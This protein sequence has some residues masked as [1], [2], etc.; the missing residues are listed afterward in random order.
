VDTQLTHRRPWL[1]TAGVALVVAC[2]VP[3][4]SL[5]ARRYLFVESVQFC[6]FAMAAP[7]LAVLG[8]PLPRGPARLLRRRRARPGGQPAADGG[9]HRPSFLPV[10]AYL[11]V[12]VVIC[13]FWRLPPVLDH[14]ARYPLLVAAE[15]VTLCAAGIGLW[16]ELI[17]SPSP[18]PG[19]AQRAAAAALAMWSIWAIAYVLGFAGGSV[20]HGYDGG[21]SHLL[22]VDDQQI[23]A[24]VLW[25]A[26]AAAFLPIVFTAGLTWL[27]DGSEPPREPARGVPG[28][29][30]WGPRAR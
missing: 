17:R 20:V 10:F 30:G 15:A 24:F 16:Q 14:L 12:W 1:A 26:S 29:R 9:G 8:T 22:T 3:P 28:V 4:L 11:I 27:K 23:T 6:V 13:L 7:A 19:P 21:G 2:L 18:R 5:L 25:A